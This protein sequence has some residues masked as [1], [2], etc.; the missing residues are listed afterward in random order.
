MLAAL[1]REPR[2]DT[3]TPPAASLFSA[4]L[5][6]GHRRPAHPGARRAAGERAAA[7]AAAAAVA[8]G[9]MPSAN[10]KWYK[11]PNE[12][13]LVLSEGDITVW[14]GDA[15]VNAANER[16]LGGGGVDG[17]IHRAAGPR[18]LE[19]CQQ[20]PEVSPGVR[21]PTGEAR[22]TRGGRLQAKYVIH[23]VGPRYES[24]EASAPL[25]ASAYKSSLDLANKH[26]LENVAFPAISTGVYGYPKDEAAEVALKAVQSS[27]GGVKY[28]EFVLFPT[29]VWAAFVAAAGRVGLEEIVAAG[30]PAASEPRQAEEAPVAEGERRSLHYSS[31]AAQPTES[32]SQTDSVCGGAA[33]APGDEVTSAAAARAPTPSAATGP[34]SHTP[35]NQPQPSGA[36]PASTVS[37]EP[38]G[39]RR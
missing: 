5:A 33:K 13:L 15:M 9:R 14:S 7:A 39:S 32:G 1:G 8:R 16:M 4:L 2:A 28:V 17:A 3:L 29:D 20:V 18:L 23:T 36:A 38:L 27:A 11:L 10:A 26:R 37:G 22:I 35:S 24:A 31:Q 25:L 34:L 19:A 30:G 6:A 12:G 21:C